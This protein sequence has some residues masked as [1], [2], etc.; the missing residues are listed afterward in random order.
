MRC[1]KFDERNQAIESVFT[2]QCDVGLL[3]GESQTIM[4]YHGGVSEQIMN[5]VR[6]TLGR[7]YNYDNIKVGKGQLLFETSVPKDPDE[8][9]KAL[10]V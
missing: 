9:I 5:Y 6:I 4:I 10:D 7:L 1:K 3:V 8:V 2:S